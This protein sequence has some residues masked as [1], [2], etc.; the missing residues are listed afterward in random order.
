MNGIKNGSPCNSTIIITDYLSYIGGNQDTFA[1]GLSKDMDYRFNLYNAIVYEG[2]LEQRHNYA[3]AHKNINNQRFYR[4]IK[5]P[6]I[7]G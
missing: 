3:N 1:Y 5:K 6:F 4:G 7:C 2:L